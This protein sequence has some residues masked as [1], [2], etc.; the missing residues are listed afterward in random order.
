VRIHVPFGEGNVPGVDEPLD[1]EEP[2]DRVDEF[3]L[4]AVGQAGVENDPISGAHMG[5]DLLAAVAQI[6][7]R[8][9]L[10][11]GIQVHVARL[12]VRRQGHTEP[13]QH[14]SQGPVGLLQANVDRA[15]LGDSDVRELSLDRASTGPFHDP[16][17]GLR[18]APTRTSRA[19]MR[20]ASGEPSALHWRRF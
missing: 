2:D 19:F 7:V 20:S 14:G 3:G 12:E 6:P 10:E 13:S 16:P 15:I 11:V 9:L 8:E 5:A 18:S 4:G 17:A 1:H